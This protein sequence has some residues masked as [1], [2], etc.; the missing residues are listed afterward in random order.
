MATA[1]VEI[2]IPVYNEEVALEPSIRRLH[3]Y[4]ADFPYSWRITIADN[5]STDATMRIATG[6]RREMSNV[7]AIHLK[8]KGRGRALRTAWLASES[9]VVA[10]MDVDLSTGLDALEPLVAPLLSGDA[11][12]AIGSRL[13]PGAHVTRGI[14]REV[15]SRVYNA[16]LR[17]GFGGSFSDAQCG[18]K[19]V[20]RDAAATLVPMIED[21]QWFFDTELL[22]LA[23]GKGMRIHEVPVR[24]V[25]D[26]DSRV[27]IIATIREDLRGMW[28][29]RGT[30]PRTRRGVRPA[31]SVDAI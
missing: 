31:V 15:I 17:V 5:A 22:L 18:F 2:V 4:L 19:A 1:N 3:A 28:R 11:D 30:I 10:Y 9:P 13:T 21:E 16:M 14:K 7:S 12:V 27:D 25:D 8:E 29:M 23:A 26:P 24:W 20:R 6:L